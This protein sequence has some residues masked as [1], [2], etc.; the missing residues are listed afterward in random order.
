MKNRQQKQFKVIL[1][2][3]CC[4]DIYQYGSVDRISPEFPVPVFVPKRRETKGGMA[5]NVEN[6]LTS[7][8]INCISYF[9]SK[10][11]KTRLIDEKS[12]HHLLRIDNDVVSQPL[13][14]F[15]IAEDT[16]DAI[17]ISDY[18]KGFISYQLIEDL[19]KRFDVPI[20]LDT[21]KK[22]LKRFKK[23]IVKI[24]DI[25]YSS[26]ISDCSNL[27]V[28]KGAGGVQYSGKLFKV[29]PLKVF[30]VCG[31]GDTFLSALTY[32]YIDT[33]DMDAAIEFAI[34][35]S[36][37]TIQHIG[38]YAPTLEEIICKK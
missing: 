26:R 36:S 16:P 38:V 34:K 25:E 20:F 30:D 10:S 28:T 27:I 12:N 29:P 4:D 3:D 37:I 21:K 22:D 23:S 2:G 17:V 11:T 7:L 35:A 33:R 31:A 1:I 8:G 5:L 24:N 32:K 19:E 14:C 9:G 13:N 6:N 18:D 15:T